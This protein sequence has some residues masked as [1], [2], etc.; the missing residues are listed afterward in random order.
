[1][2]ANPHSIDLSAIV[3][4][5]LEQAEP[6]VL[7]SMLSQLHAGVDGCRG[8]RGVRRRLRH[9]QSGADQLPQRLPGP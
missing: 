4:Q 8:R 2:T 1:M 5:H 9:P 7:R 3:A 6:D